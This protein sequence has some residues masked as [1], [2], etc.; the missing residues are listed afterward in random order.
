[1]RRIFETVLVMTLVTLMG[2]ADLRAS[3]VPSEGLIKRLKTDG[4]LLTLAQLNGYDREGF[5]LEYNRKGEFRRQFNFERD[6]LDGVAKGYYPDRTLLFERQFKNG[7]FD[8]PSRKYYPNGQLQLEI[9]YA[10][11]FPVGLA[12]LYDIN[13]ELTQENY[14][15]MGELKSVKMYADGILIKEITY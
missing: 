2:S 5:W 15:R 4:T 8:G 13:G 7:L 10:D 6:R 12:R 1:M 14:Y 11:N 3:G 9:H